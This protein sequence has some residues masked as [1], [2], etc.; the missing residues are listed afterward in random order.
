[1]NA[2]KSWLIRIRWI[3]IPI[4]FLALC[5]GFQCQ[6]FIAKRDRF[7]TEFAGQPSRVHL[8]KEYNRGGCM[9]LSDDAYLFEIDA[10]TMAEC[11]RKNQLEPDSRSYPFSDGGLRHAAGIDVNDFDPAAPTV[12]FF[13]SKRH[14]SWVE[15][16]YDSKTHRA[17]VFTSAA[18]ML[19]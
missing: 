17:F 14:F 11:I 6:Q 18:L 7:P 16:A 4:L 1:M 9:G 13:R 5:Y 19:G 3:S 2:I 8:L 10:A 15:I 12:R